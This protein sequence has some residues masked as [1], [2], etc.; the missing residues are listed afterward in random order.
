MKG[1]KKKLCGDDDEHVDDQG[2]KGR[3]QIILAAYGGR[4]VLELGGWRRG[5]TNIYQ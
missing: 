1:E 2:L 4:S 3:M 5:A